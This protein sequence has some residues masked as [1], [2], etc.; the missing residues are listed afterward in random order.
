MSLQTFQTI[1][2]FTYYVC[3]RELYTFR[4][5]VDNADILIIGYKQT[6]VKINKN[7]RS[8]NPTIYSS[9]FALVLYLAAN[10]KNDM[11]SLVWYRS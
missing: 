9:L 2:V 7:I 10:I 1:S 3:S 8:D 11:D 4:L 5:Y 6:S